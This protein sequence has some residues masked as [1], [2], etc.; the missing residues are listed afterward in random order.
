MRNDFMAGVELFNEACR[1]A[2]RQQEEPDVW[3]QETFRESASHEVGDP[4]PAAVPPL[5]VF[6]RP[7]V[8]RLLEQPAAIDG[9]AAAL[10]DYLVSWLS[11]LEPVGPVPYDGLSYSDIMGPNRAAG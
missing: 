9:F 6:L 7:I 11:G 5:R 8:A 2:D 3:L 10:G 1:E 4:P